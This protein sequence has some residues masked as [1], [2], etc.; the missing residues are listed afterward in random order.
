MVPGL[1]DFCQ[2]TDSLLSNRMVMVVRKSYMDDTCLHPAE[3]CVLESIARAH[4]KMTVRTFFGKKRPNC[5]ATDLVLRMFSNIEWIEDGTDR[6]L[7]TGAQCCQLL[8]RYG[9]GI[10][11][12]STTLT[13]R[14]L[15][16]ISNALGHTF[17]N[18][19]SVAHEDVLIFS[20]DHPFLNY[21]LPFLL[22][23][24][25]TLNYTLSEAL[26]SFCD[27]SGDIFPLT[28]DFICGGASLG[29]VTSEF[30]YPWNSLEAE[31]QLF[32][33]LMDDATVASSLSRLQDSF[34]A[35]FYRSPIKAE[36]PYN[37]LFARLAHTYCPL[38]YAN[39]I[40]I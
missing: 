28:Q 34:T 1:A 24:E 8:S 13:L 2:P 23:G 16:C 32:R 14:P 7:S 31:N 38:I 39:F 21:S 12:A 40:N 19:R 5:P 25:L 22:D 11:L 17:S 9:G 33:P 27:Y 3:A 37:S 30:F 4:S 29:L 18:G 6:E 10:C 20:S 36:I 26:K 35:N 15:Q